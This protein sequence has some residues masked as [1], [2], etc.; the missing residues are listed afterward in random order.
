M[1]L[2]CKVASMSNSQQ[3]ANIDLYKE[4]IER[5]LSILQ[6]ARQFEGTEPNAITLATSDLKGHVTARTVMLRHTSMEGLVFYTHE[7]SRKGLQLAENPRG[8]VVLF[9]PRLMK[10]IIVEGTVRV[11]SES[12]ADANWQSRP[13]D[14]QIAAWAS[15]QSSPVQDTA[16]LKRQLQDTKKRFRD[17]RIPRPSYW[18]GYC[19]V[20]GRIEFWK[21]GWHHLNERVSY[22]KTEDGWIRQLLSP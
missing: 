7:S 16:V 15:D 13:R 5:L 6:E 14:S 20:P 21:A 4:A 18:L 11:L 19:L 12:K 10:Q 3:T 9:W 22:E 17:Q 1:I 8:C 2:S